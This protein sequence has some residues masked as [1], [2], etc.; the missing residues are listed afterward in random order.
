MALALIALADLSMRAGS[1]IPFYTDRG[2][3]PRQV[4]LT[5]LSSSWRLSLLLISGDVAVQA[6]LLTLAG[7][8]ALALLVGFGPDRRRSSYGCSSCRST[9]A[10][11]R[12]Q[13]RRHPDAAAVLLGDVPALG[14]CWSV[15]R[16][17]TPDQRPLSTRFLSFATVGLSRR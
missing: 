6:V 5:E 9:C 14:A 1:L 3:L 16:T 7:A 13:Q 12:P 10:T 15:D 17:R 11:T 4:L 2:V 8:A